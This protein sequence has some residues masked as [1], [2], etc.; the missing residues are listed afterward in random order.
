MT[1]SIASLIIDKFLDE[2][3]VTSKQILSSVDQEF[4]ELKAQ[5]MEW[6]WVP[7]EEYVKGH[8]WSSSV[9]IE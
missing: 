2:F 3:L 5:Y 6:E 4:G 7:N 8:V 1:E 9:S